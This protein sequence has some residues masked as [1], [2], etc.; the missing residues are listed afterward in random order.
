MSACFPLFQALPGASKKHNEKKDG[1]DKK[2]AAA[3]DKIKTKTYE[4][5]LRELHVELVKLQE[6][7]RHRGLKLCMVFEGRGG[8]G[9]GGT[10]NLEEELKNEISLDLAY[11]H[12]HGADREGIA[13]W[14]WPLK[15][16]QSIC[17]W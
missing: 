17:C 12:A 14:I 7:M 13:N 2:E 4:K 3:C 6:W 8:F 1:A 15:N 10:I 5:V 9:K 11:A 16:D